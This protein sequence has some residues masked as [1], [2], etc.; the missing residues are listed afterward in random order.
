LLHGGIVPEPLAMW[1]KHKNNCPALRYR[2]IFFAIIIAPLIYIGVLSIAFFHWIDILRMPSEV[3]LLKIFLLAQLGMI[4]LGTI[5]L[6]L[7]NRKYRKLKKKCK[8]TSTDNAAL[9]IDVA[10]TRRLNDHY[11]HIMRVLAHDLRS[12]LG[13][14][15]GIAGFLLGDEEFSEDHREMLELIKSTGSHTLEMIN[16]LLKADIRPD[17]HFSVEQLNISEL[18]YES[19]ELLQYKASEK[20][21]RVIFESE[22]QQ[23]VAIANR[24]K[25]WR[26][27]NNLIMNAIKFSYSGGLIK[28]SIRKRDNHALIAIT[29]TGIGIRERDREKVFE[30]F[31]SARNVGTMGEQPFGIGLAISKKIIEAHNGQI[32]VESN[33][34]EGTIFFVTMPLT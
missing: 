18:L 14:I 32:W 31:T 15:T 33:A 25:T 22:D 30:M 23:I 17:V 11:I 3:F 20:Q 6:F 7:I 19:V 1:C 2:T 12:P 29:D 21:Q 9:R 10:E 26:V 5:L 16:E 8:T 28:V 24:E 4:G 13:G 34:D 27:F